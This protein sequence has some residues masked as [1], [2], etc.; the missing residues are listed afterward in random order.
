MIYN[1]DFDVKYFQIKNELIEKC[2]SSSNFYEYSENDV[3]DICD[4]LYR[5]ELSSVFFANNILDDKIDNGIRNILEKIKENND[6]KNM[7]DELIFSTFP[8]DNDLSYNQEI[9]NNNINSHFIIYLVLFSFD[10]FHLTHKIICQILTKQ[11]ISS[12]L[13]QN[14]KEL[15]KN[16]LNPLNE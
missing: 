5:D 10:V 3:A 2:K 14:I 4:K 8:P 12:D 7:L 16:I 13:L 1:T 11:E 6:F 15:T 9:I